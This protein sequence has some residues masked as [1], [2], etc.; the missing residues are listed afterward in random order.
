MRWNILSASLLALLALELGCGGGG[1][2]TD[3][4]IGNLDVTSVDL[5][6]QP[7]RDGAATLPEAGTAD[8]VAPDAAS[9]DLPPAQNDTSA[10]DIAPPVDLP[11]VDRPDVLNVT[12]A[13]Q[14]DSPAVRDTGAP[15]DTAN[16]AC[17]TLIRPAPLSAGSVV[18]AQQCG[19]SDG[20]GSH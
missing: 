6:V 20:S 4:S 8:V 14:E 13:T 15:L 17:P 18:P 1:N 7:N 5:G 16:P 19:L 3:G 2:G 12:D 11:L 10:D 9:R